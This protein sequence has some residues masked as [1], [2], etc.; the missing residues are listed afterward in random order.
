MNNYVEELVDA[1]C[2]CTMND[3]RTIITDRMGEYDVVLTW[4]GDSEKGLVSITPD[5]VEVLFENGLVKNV[6]R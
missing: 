2:I 5:E 1:K 4:E 3:K 6:A